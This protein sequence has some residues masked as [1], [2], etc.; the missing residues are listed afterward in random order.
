MTDKIN[1]QG[2]L[3]TYLLE[4]EQLL[5]QIQT[6]VLQE[7]DKTY[8]EKESIHEIFRGIHTIKGISAMMMYD[9]VTK[10]SHKLEDVLYC[11]RESETKQPPAAELAE[12]ILKVTDFISNEMTKIGSGESADGKATEHLIQLNSFLDKIR[13]DDQMEKAEVKENMYEEP[14]QFYIP[15]KVSGTS[16]FYKI[17]LTFRPGLDLAN[18]HAYK[19]VYALKEIAEDMIYEPEDIISDDNTAEEILKKGFDILLQTQKKEE[20][21]HKI[22]KTGY[23]LTG[24]EIISGTAREYCKGFTPEEEKTKE[25]MPDI[26]IGRTYVP[27]DFVIESKE[28]GKGKKL[29]KDRMERT[30]YIRVDVKK[31]DM[32]L[33]LMEDVKNSQ[34]AL[35]GNKD[36]RVEGL[37]LENFDMAA[38]QMLK[39]SAKL[40]SA[41]MAMRMMSLSNTFQRM[42]RIVF[43]TARQ[44]G[45]EIDFE[46][47]GE[48]VQLD[49]NVVEHLLAPLMHIVRNSVDHGI[50]MPQEREAIGKEKRGKIILSAK[51]EPSRVCISVEDNGR[52]LSRDKILEKARKQ[53]LISQWEK[54]EDYTEEEVYRLITLPGF[55][56]KEEITE[57][58]G[59]GVGMDV[60]IS[61]LQEINGSLEIESEE[62]VG[63]KM[64]MFVPTTIIKNMEV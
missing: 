39:A 53:G 12:Q 19:I 34:N 36:L 62:G 33:R 25:A 45:K 44:L 21:L 37:N 50:E 48:E 24:V 56:T 6:I 10:I 5:E 1:A 8:F 55:S 38:E 30:S 46:M 35:L 58:S 61:N 57:Y 15:P 59:R 27:G 64:T 52:G 9:E 17:H 13:D 60:V 2:M 43:E 22:L 11:L 29:A 28:P 42:N 4:C 7:K 26:N 49:K 32:L 18:V 47:V 40:Q 54:E 16:C 14:Q 20:D 63:S 51:L 23:A 41:I 3:D 31:M